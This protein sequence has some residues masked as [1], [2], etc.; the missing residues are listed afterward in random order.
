VRSE[1]DNDIDALMDTIATGVPLQYAVPALGADGDLTMTTVTTREGA[2]QHYAGVR[3]VHDIVDWQ[4]FVELRN[5]WCVFFEGVV[6]QRPRRSEDV[7]KGH[8]VVLFVLSEQPG[9]TGE[10]AWSKPHGGLGALA[11]RPSADD[12]APALPQNRLDSLEFHARYVDALKRADVGTLRTL[13][14]DNIEV[15]ARSYLTDQ[16]V[17]TAIKGSD[18]ALGYYDAFFERHQVED[19]SIVN[20]VAE[21]WYVYSELLWR[22]AVDGR[23]DPV[24]FR[25]AEVLVL[26]EGRVSV[27]MGYGTDP[28]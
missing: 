26:R 18:A 2:L 4:A 7:T 6:T 22:A 11:A 8:A 12:G 25:T 23:S 3:A 20:V 27:R 28:V 14:G 10:L 19:V 13:I 17:F 5:D 24:R 15:G 16:P 9:I 21:D 1:F